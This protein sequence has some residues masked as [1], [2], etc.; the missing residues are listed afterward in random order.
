M[1]DHWILPLLSPH[2]CSEIKT[3]NRSTRHLYNLWALAAWN[4]M[5]AR[6]RAGLEY[7]VSLRNFTAYA[8][9]V[10]GLI[11]C[12]PAGVATGA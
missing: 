1:S 11:V 7:S 2:Q 8:C 12:G 4:D 5:V 3:S 6:H 10:W 9:D